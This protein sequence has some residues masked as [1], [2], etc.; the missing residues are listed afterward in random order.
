MRRFRPSFGSHPIRRAGGWFTA[1]AL[2]LALLLGGCSAAD[3]PAD[4]YPTGTASDTSTAASSSASGTTTGVTTQPSG[5]AADST[6]STG[7]TSGTTTAA[8]ATRTTSVAGTTRTTSAPT[9]KPSDQPVGPAVT[10]EFRGMWVSYIEL[11]SL[12]DGK[13]AAAAQAALDEVMDRCVSYG[14]N[15]VIFHARAN[16]DAYYQSQIFQPASAVKDL[17]AGGFDPL[18]YAVR[19]AHA[20][21]LQLHAWINPYRIGQNRSYIV[22]GYEDDTFTRPASN[23]NTA[24]YYLPTSQRAQKLILDG[25]REVL[26]YGVDGIQFDDY[27]YPTGQMSASLETFEQE[28]YQASGGKLSVGDWRR[29]AVDSLVAAVHVL[30]KNKGIV[31][32]IS[33]S[34]DVAKTRDQM[35]ADVKKWMAS[36]G[37]VDYICPQIYFGFEHGSAPFD[38]TTDEWLTYPRHSGVKLYVGL[39]IYKSGAEDPWAGSGKREWIEHKDII[40]RQVEYLRTK[41][42]VDGALFYSYSY[43][44]SAKKETENLLPLLTG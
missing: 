27:F 13:S 9:T 23:G 44:Q 26:T 35:Y 3:P 1:A 37:Y 5:S 2:G 25:I 31:F 10:G 30:T 41:S 43:F 15:A 38:K 14:M 16:S 7:S 33:P 22:P 11:N 32:G 20:L 24:W 36:P 8:D 40:K 28:G 42:Q 6:G 34:H 21:G 17:I 18:A 12:L 29:A 4:F 19:A 39:A